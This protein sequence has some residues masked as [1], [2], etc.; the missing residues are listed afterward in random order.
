MDAIYYEH[1]LTVC[2][3]SQSAR[4]LLSDLVIVKLILPGYEGVPHIW[5]GES[6]HAKAV[7]ADAICNSGQHSLSTISFV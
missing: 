7:E 1:H 2:E 6:A 5:I 3:L 4:T